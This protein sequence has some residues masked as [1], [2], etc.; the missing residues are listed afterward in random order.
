MKN[1]RTFLLALVVLAPLTTSVVPARAQVVAPAQAQ[2]ADLSDDQVRQLGK[3]VAF[4]YEILS[5][6]LDKSVTKTGLVNYG[7]VKGSDQLALFVRAVGLADMKNFPVFTNKDEDGKPVLDQRQPLAFYVNAY[8][9]LFLK[10]VSDAYPIGS[11]D[12]IPDLD[13]KPRLVAGQMMSL[14]ELRKKITDLD[15][16][17]IFVLMDG[18]RSGPRALQ[19]AVL[20]FNLGD[21][22]NSAI[23]AYVDDPSRVTAPSRLGNEVTVSPWLLKADD[24]FKPNKSRRRGDGIKEILKAYTSNNASRRYF[25]AGS[26]EVK[27][28][29]VQ[30]GL[31]LPSNSFTG[32]GAG[33]LGGEQ[34]G[35]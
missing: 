23:K 27:Y 32:I 17:A 14:A 6:V 8:N 5:R 10:A 13:G 4:P 35:G 2:S 24:L 1:Q 22:M 15:P 29:P 19:S 7:Q 12:Q 33:D 21:D 30:N 16:R 9:G 3:G 11:V 31:D 25:G 28:L 34:P 18:T 20:G 26:Y